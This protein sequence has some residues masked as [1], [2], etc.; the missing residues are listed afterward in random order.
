MFKVYDNSVSGNR[1]V[2][3]VEFY[4]IKDGF[5]TFFRENELGKF[6]RTLSINA[7]TVYE[8]SIVR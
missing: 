6:D 2:T 3:D 8:I 4:Q 7:E 5:V 1:L